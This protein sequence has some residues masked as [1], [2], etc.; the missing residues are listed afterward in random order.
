MT[1]QSRLL[2][3]HCLPFHEP[4]FYPEEVLNWTSTKPV[5]KNCDKFQVLPNFPG[6]YSV[7]YSPGLFLTYPELYSIYWLCVL[8]EFLNAKVLL[9]K[10][11]SKGNK[12]WS[13]ESLIYWDELLNFLLTT[14]RAGINVCTR[15]LPSCSASQRPK[16]AHMS[17][18]S[19][20]SLAV[21]FICFISF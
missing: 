1:S 15:A 9:P 21:T 3:Y 12:L 6:N 20:T 11:N 7:S 10:S 18:W 2:P 17:P 5:M 16:I 19:A 4:Q 14:R 13:P 8:C